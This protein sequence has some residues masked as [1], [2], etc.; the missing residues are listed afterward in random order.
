MVPSVPLPIV[1]SIEAEGRSTVRSFSFS[2]GGCIN[3]GGKLTTSTGDFFLKWND[4]KTFPGMFAAEARGLKLLRSATALAVPEVIQVGEADSFQYL[5]LQ[6][7]SPGT[8]SADY[9]QHF[10]SGL[11]ALHK[12]SAHQFGLD[13]DNYIGS[14]PQKN[15]G[16]ARWVDFFIEQRLN[17]QL[18]MAQEDGKLDLSILKKF[19]RLFDRLPSMF[20][21]EAPALLHGDLWGGNIMTNS[22]G[23]P[24]LIDPAVYFGHRE[25]DLAMTRLFG[26]FDP[27]FVRNYE[28]V[29][30]LLPGYDDR[31]DLY[32]LYPLLVHVNLFGSG[33]AG[34]VV[35]ILNHFV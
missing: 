3:H 14:L 25:A 22:A 35:S 10:G 20:P 29:Y 12:T 9:W 2:S 4:L 32:N 16:T 13:H 21:E 19:D 18:R 8:R 30:P 23:A 28:E 34:Q 17:T 1:E 27:S 6:Y 11:A 33:Y 26:G 7:I 5:V 24:C 15:K 31:L